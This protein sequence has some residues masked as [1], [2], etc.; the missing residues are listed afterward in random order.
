MIEPAE[1]LISSRSPLYRGSRAL[2]S[3][4]M[5]RNI[6]SAR[7][8]DDPHRAVADPHLGR[9]AAA[10]PAA[11]HRAAAPPR[12]ANGFGS[13]IRPFVTMASI[14]RTDASVG[15]PPVSPVP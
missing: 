9:R 3:G 5:S 7:A 12:G 2:C 15:E 6:C 13:A 4:L 1:W 10:A 11:R 14:S 8:L